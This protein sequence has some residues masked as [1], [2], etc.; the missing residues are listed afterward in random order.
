MSCIST[1]TYF[2]MNVCVYVGVHSIYMNVY[3]QLPQRRQLRGGGSV[4][5]PKRTRGEQEGVENKNT[6]ST[7][8]NLNKNSENPRSTSNQSSRPCTVLQYPSR[9]PS[10][11]VS[12][13]TRATPHICPIYTYMY[14][15]ITQY[16]CTQHVCMYPKMC[17]A[18]M[19]GCLS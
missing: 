3:I 18:H 17:V 4:G 14:V 2:N 15:C 1:C 5:C 7:H 13:H 9:K 19:S 11:H 16:V 8:I 12:E 6:Q 10:I